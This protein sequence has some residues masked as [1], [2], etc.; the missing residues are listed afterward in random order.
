M[1]KIICVLS[2]S[3]INRDSRVQRQINTARSLAEVTVIGYGLWQPPNNVH[4]HQL[5]K[6][7]KDPLFRIKYLFLLVLGKV[8]PSLYEKAFWLKKE[9]SQALKILKKSNYDLIHA[10]DWDGLPVAVNG[11][12]GKNTKVLFDAHEYT[13]EQNS[14]NWLIRIFVIPFRVYMLRM[15][16][17][18]K[19][20]MITVGQGISNLYKKNFDWEPD[21]ILNASYY[22]ESA[23]H[24]V[25]PEK[26]KLIHHGWAIKGRYLEDLIKMTPFLNDQ[27]HLFFMLLSRKNDTYL[28]KLH[29]LSQ[30]ICKERITFLPPVS[31]A[32]LT[33]EINKFDIGIHCLNTKNANHLYALPNKFFDYILAGLGVVIPPLPA[34]AEIIIQHDIGRV[35]Q[36]Q[37]PKDMANVLNALTADEINHFKHNSLALAKVYNA[38][39]EMAKLSS[40]YTELI[41]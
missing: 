5:I 26:I 19:I 17:S 16:N 37:S 38:E 14:D 28:K 15:H 8:F 34:M 35:A 9:Y 25:N 6:T 7:Q 22:E 30:K 29:S 4:F 36:S 23:F 2:F 3:A 20:R 33:Q 1:P 31:P 32:A 12:C 13:P 10:N 18:Q 39:R 24:K 41:K 21:S 11:A 40:I 27:Y